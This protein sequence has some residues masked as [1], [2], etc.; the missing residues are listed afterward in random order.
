MQD[1]TDNETLPVC[2]QVE[3]SLEKRK[4]SCLINSVSILERKIYCMEEYESYSYIVD[5]A[6][7]VTPA[8]IS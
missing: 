5:G 7:V 4:H 3:Y 6:T 8:M 1:A 2:L